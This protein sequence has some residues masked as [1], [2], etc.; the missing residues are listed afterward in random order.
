MVLLDI[1]LFRFG[2]IARLSQWGGGG[3]FTCAIN[4]YLQSR[5]VPRGGGGVAPCRRSRQKSSLYNLKGKEL[6][7]GGELMSIGFSG[8]LFKLDKTKENGRESVLYVTFVLPILRGVT[9]L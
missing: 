9:G 4:F 3:D 1:K 5:A 6:G 7:S 2:Y 8:R